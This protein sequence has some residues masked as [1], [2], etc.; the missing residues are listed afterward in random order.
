[1]KTK[2]GFLRYIRSSKNHTWFCDFWAL[3]SDTFKLKTPPWH[4]ESVRLWTNYFISLNLNPHLQNQETRSLVRLM[5]KCLE[6]HIAQTWHKV[7]PQQQL[8]SLLSITRLSGHSNQG[9]CMVQ[10]DGGVNVLINSGHRA[11][12]NAFFIFIFW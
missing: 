2:G 9:P 4:L 8:I 11:A 10:L 3:K 7:E 12:L 1:M 6:N 5:I